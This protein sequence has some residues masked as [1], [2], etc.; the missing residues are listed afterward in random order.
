VIAFLLNLDAERELA[1]PRYRTSAETA[2]RIAALR[3]RLAWLA[4]DDRV[5]GEHRVEP[6]TRAVAFC[7]TPR[8]L[9]KIA[10]AGLTP[11]RA[12]TLEVLRRVNARAFCAELGQTLP[13]ARY[14]RS[15]DALRAMLGEGTWLLKRDFGFAGRERRQVRGG[16][17][18]AST[19]GFARRSFDRGEGLQVEPWLELGLELC[20]HGYL[21]PGGHSLLAPPRLQ[22]CDAR[23][24]WVCS[25]PLPGHVLDAQERD[26]LAESSQLAVRAL[27]AA[28][29]F[30]PFALDAFRYRSEA[31]KL[32]LQ[33]RSE[34]NARLSMGYPRS[35]LLEALAAED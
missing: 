28:G 6:G 35:L 11:P 13:G 21:T 29:Y 2:A 20:Q 22:R 34:L 19:E 10:Q 18:D 24:S 17:L 25:E 26:L 30:G 4:P 1:D 9:A 7:P 33:P 14:V 5:I 8:A 16:V 31:G 12:P 27:R 3:P 23:G 15:L 32:V